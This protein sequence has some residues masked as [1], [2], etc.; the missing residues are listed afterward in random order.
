MRSLRS[1]PRRPPG[2]RS[3]RVT[4][5]DESSRRMPSWLPPTRSR[6]PPST[7]RM[8]KPS[9]MYILCLLDI[10]FCVLNLLNHPVFYATWR[11]MSEP[12]SLQVLLQ[13]RKLIYGHKHEEFILL[14]NS[15]ICLYEFQNIHFL[16]THRVFD[17]W[18]RVSYVNTMS[19]YH[20]KESCYRVACF[21]KWCK[22]QSSTDY[23]VWTLHIFEARINIIWHWW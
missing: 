17:D 16:K 10:V 1:P 3:R 18:E 22:R 2:T 12:L 7:S 20:W 9:Y 14:I 4:A 23:W 19:Y 21:Q 6:Q 15:Y 5:M 13:S 8:T 11:I